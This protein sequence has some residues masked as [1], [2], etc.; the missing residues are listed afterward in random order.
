MRTELG[1]SAITQERFGWLVR[2]VLEGMKTAGRDGS[3]PRMFLK[4]DT[5]VSASRGILS[6]PQQPSNLIPAYHK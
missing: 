3:D 6:A 1:S 4:M 5:F 2:R